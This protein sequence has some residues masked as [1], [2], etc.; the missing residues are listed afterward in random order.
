[1]IADLG[2]FILRASLSLMMII[3]HGLPKL[4]GFQTMATQFPDPLNIGNQFSL[5]LAIFG[6]VFA[7]FMVLI[8][9]KTRYFAAPVLITMLVAAFIVH[10]ADPWNKVEFPLLYAIPY[11]ALMFMGSGRIS[12]DHLIF[13][14]D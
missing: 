5:V 12:L 1:M 4:M 9:F 13:K 11:F 14:K 2:L 3:S 10:A 6:E 8:G 7:P